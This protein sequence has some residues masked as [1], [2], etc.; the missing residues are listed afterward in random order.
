M[1]VMFGVV[2]TLLGHEFGSFFGDLRAG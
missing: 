2:S 1:K